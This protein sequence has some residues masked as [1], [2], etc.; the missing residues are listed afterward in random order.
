[1]CTIS[2][3][4]V[5]ISA[6]PPITWSSS[7][8]HLTVYTSSQEYRLACSKGGNGTFLLTPLDH[9]IK[10]FYVS[11]FLS[12]PLHDTNTAVAALKDG[13]E[14]LTYALPF[15]SGVIVP[16]SRL[17]GKRNVTEIHPSPESL[18]WIPM[19]QIKYHLDTTLVATCSPGS[20]GYSEFDDTWSSLPIIIPADRPSPIA[21]LQ[22]NVFPD[23]ILLYMTLSP[24]V[25]DRSGLRTIPKMLATYCLKFIDEEQ[26][27]A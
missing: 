25:F 3:L 24:A 7:M 14:R 9:I 26:P 22:T 10:D 20:S 18:E 2:E 27:P 6:A 13:V 21:R 15:L 11:C 5:P 19:L 4:K 8:I 12:F 17:P 1:V 23:G 16:S